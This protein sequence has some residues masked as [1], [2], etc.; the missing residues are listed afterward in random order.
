MLDLLNGQQRLLDIKPH[1]SWESIFEYIPTKDKEI[2]N[3]FISQLKCATDPYIGAKKHTSINNLYSYKIGDYKLLAEINSADVTILGV[4]STNNNNSEYTAIDKL[5]PPKVTI[6]I[7]VFNTARY[8]KECIDS[9][10]KQTY[11]NLEILIL[12]NKSTDNSYDVIKQYD[13]ER[14]RVFT[15]VEGILA[16]VRNVAMQYVTGD[17][18]LFLDSDDHYIRLDAIAI[19]VNKAIQEELDILGFNS[20]RTSNFSYN[21]DEIK[22][23]SKSVFTGIDFTELGGLFFKLN[24]YSWCHLFRTSFIK[25]YSKLFP[26]GRYYEDIAWVGFYRLRAPRIS[27]VN[28]IIHHYR[29]RPEAITSTIVQP[30]DILYSF[31]DLLNENIIFFDKNINFKRHYLCHMSCI[32]IFYH[33]NPIIYNSNLINL[34]KHIKDL[35][36]CFTNFCYYFKS[37]ADKDLLKSYALQPNQINKI[38]FITKRP[39]LL[40]YINYVIKKLAKNLLNLEYDN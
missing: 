12:D 27:A 26:K 32:V 15:N 20:L 40:I 10:I 2:I 7:P 6:V 30:W 31:I 14:I 24:F 23:L 9:V 4:E 22:Y 19:L 8:L 11:N 1:I 17:F 18:L 13:D 39:T 33:L 34:Y 36:R 35:K 3:Y 38:K 5:Y 21:Q 37:T 28:D 29:E 25:K 16:D